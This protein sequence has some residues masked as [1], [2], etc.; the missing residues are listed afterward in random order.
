MRRRGR[1]KAVSDS[2]FAKKITKTNPARLLDSMGLAYCL[3]S[4]NPPPND[5]S[6]ETAATILNLPFESVYKTLI[7]K[8]D[9]TGP[10]A[11]CLP[12]S[13]EL[14]LKALAAVSSNRSVSLVEARVLFALTGYRRGGCSPLG[15]RRPM[16]IFFDLRVL[17]LEKEAVNAGAKGLMLYLG[18]LDLLKAASATVAE[19]AT[20]SR[21]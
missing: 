2:G 5:L 15:L 13:T 8:G 4:F 6:A 1:Q 19:I 20:Q 7:L 11:A 17:K 3:L 14:N 10:L 16:P 18:P 12:A 21:G 9:R